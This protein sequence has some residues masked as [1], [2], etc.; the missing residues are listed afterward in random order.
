VIAADVEEL[1][2][3]YLGQ[4]FTNVGVDMPVSPPLPFYLVNCIAAPSDWIT[5]CATVSVHAFAATRTAASTAA[6]AM[7]NVMNPWVFTPKLS[8]TLSNGDTTGID[9]F[10][11]VEA[12]CWRNYEDPNMERYCGRYRID[13]RNNQTS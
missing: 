2:V 4:T 12:P 5:M 3:A 1:V 7:H 13:L 6:R 9:R 10:C 11:I 8:F